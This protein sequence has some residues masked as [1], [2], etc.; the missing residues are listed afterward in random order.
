[1]SDNTLAVA[2]TAA[3]RLA[4]RRLP[5]RRCRQLRALPARLPKGI[6]GFRGLV[7]GRTPAAI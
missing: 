2:I 7:L 5:R 1:V 3:S 6:E 4:F